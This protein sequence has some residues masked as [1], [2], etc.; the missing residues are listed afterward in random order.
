MVSLT[1]KE[2]NARSVLLVDNYQRSLLQ[3]W[4]PPY[5]TALSLLP[6]KTL[7]CKSGAGKNFNGKV[8]FFKRPLRIVICNLSTVLE[9]IIGIYSQRLAHEG[10]SFPPIVCSFSRTKRHSLHNCIKNKRAW[11]KY[12]YTQCRKSCPFMLLNLHER[13]KCTITKQVIQ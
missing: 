9:D 5:F 6:V 11:E 7:S 4:A 13:S 1:T 12:F 3:Q 8:Y 10:F 2:K